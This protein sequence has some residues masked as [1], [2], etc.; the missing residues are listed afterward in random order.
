MYVNPLESIKVAMSKL[1]ARAL[2]WKSN[3]DE[4]DGRVTY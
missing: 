3:A 1:V 2:S 4:S